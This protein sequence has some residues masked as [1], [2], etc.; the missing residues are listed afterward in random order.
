MKDNLLTEEREDKIAREGEAQSQTGKPANLPEK[1]WD[2]QS[3]AIRVDALIASY[4][5][6]ERKLSTM[7]PSPE[8]PEGRSRALKAMGVP[9]SADDYIL[10]LSHG[11][12]EADSSIN[13]R[14]HAL[15]FTQEQV[16]AVYDLAAEKMVPMIVEIADEFKAD[17]EIERLIAAFGGAEKW[18]EI[19]R[20]LLNYGRKN[21]PDDVLTS[22][23]S[24]FEGV[25]A[26]YRMMQGG[27]EPGMA[28]ADEPANG[29][30]GERELQT[31]MRDPKYW[32]DRDPAFIEKVSEG[33]RRLY[34]SA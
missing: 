3:G 22:L 8:T 7:M 4:L 18:S 30:N 9:D 27:G 1:F 13:R 2:A 31:M 15:G 26:L 23:A 25:M 20:Q 10:N 14:L 34:Q 29:A 33:F 16:Q 6:L 32:R 5:E 28:R 21:L 12:F 19:S 17:R 11:L 24:S